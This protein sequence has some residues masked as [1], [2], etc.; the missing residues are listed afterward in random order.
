MTDP[1]YLTSDALR[2]V[3]QH[4]EAQKPNEACGFVVGRD[5]VGMD[6]IPMDNVHPEPATHYRMDD[7]AVLKV[8]ETLDT[9][10]TGL[11]VIAAYHSHPTTV[12]QPSVDDIASV[13]DLSLP[14]LIVSLR[15]G[16]PRARAWRY[17]LAAIGVK[18]VDECAIT[19][20]AADGQPELPPGP[21][22]LAVGNRVKITYS[23]YA[24]T[25]SEERITTTAMILESTPFSVSLK[26]DRVQKAKPTSL[27]VER[28]REVEVLFES[29]AG[30]HARHEMIIHARHLGTILERGEMMHLSGPLATLLATTFPAT[31]D[32]GKS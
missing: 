17:R 28:I 13:F 25:V 1:L 2:A 21:W 7:A 10:A 6:V 14:Y 23:R 24:K 9:A 11:D 18:E 30:R 19:V 22:A 4:C 32:I 20:A 8:F 31:Y 3:V 15:A 29:D 16:A 27:A 5:G 26:P 12:A